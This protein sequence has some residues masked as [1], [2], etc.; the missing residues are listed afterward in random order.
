MLHAY[1]TQPADL[2]R[3]KQTLEA[4]VVPIYDWMFDTGLHQCD[5]LVYA[6]LFDELR[7]EPFTPQRIEQKKIAERIHYT[8]Q[9]VGGSVDLL[10]KLKYI[11]TRGE[12]RN[13]LFSL[14]PFDTLG[15]LK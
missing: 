13:M 7:H 8:P 1:E 15:L 10:R 3:I 12:R 5:L 6:A 9:A 2:D 4:D 11:F 14:Y